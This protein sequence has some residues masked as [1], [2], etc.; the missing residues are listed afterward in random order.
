MSESPVKAAGTSA[1]PKSSPSK[2]EIDTATQALNH[3]AQGKR[4][5]VV[6]DISSAVNSLQEA[7]RLL[8]E[9][10]GETAPECGDA[11]F[12]YGRALLEMA[13]MENG[14]LGNALDGVPE[15][16]DMDNSQ[17]ENPEKMTE[18]EKIE[19]TEQVGKALEEN[20]KDLEDS[21]KNS[22]TPKQ[23][24]DAKPEESSGAKE[25]EM[26][27]DSAEVSKDSKAEDGGEKKDNVEKSEGDKKN[28]DDTDGTSSSKVEASLVDSES[29]DKESKSEKEEAVDTKDEAKEAEKVT[30]KVETKEEEG[31]TE[32]KGEGNKE[33]V[34]GE[35]KDEKGK[36]DAK[37]EEKVKTEAKEEEMETDVAE[38]KEGSTEGEEEEEEEGDGDAEG[39]GEGEGE[40]E[41]QEES[42]DEGEKDEGASQEEGE[43][44]EEDE[45]EVSNLQLS[46]EMLELAK[47]IY[48]KQQDDNPEMAKKV[49]Q[50]YLKLGEVGLESENY[51]QGIEDFKQ[52]LQIQEKILEEDNRCLAETHYQLGVAHSFS[53]DFDK[54]IESFKA[55]MKVIEMRITNL[56]KQIKEK[57]EWTE[58]Q[59]KKDAAE[60]P[61]PFYTEEGE[62][63]ELNKLLPEMKEKVTDME[64]M[65]KD[66]KDR[67]Q[68]AAKLPLDPVEAFMANAI[69]GTSKAGSSSQT[70][71]DAPSSSTSAAPTEIKASNITHLVRKKQRKP[72]DEVEG[73]E[74]KKAKG[75]NG[76]AHGTTNGTTNGT[77]GTNGHSETMET[78]EKETPSNGASTEELKEKAADEMKKKTD[79]I[80]GQTE[81]AS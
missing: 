17:V 22:K 70:G 42:Q 44:T 41:S 61:D 48:Q 57:K 56:E 73:E 14:V 40:E 76:E 7:C 52:C 77:N 35:T 72:E 27:V 18:D 6:G 13:R 66:S 62:I 71:F 25:S 55:A 60:R 2:K 47:V 80:T 9:Q 39:D 63:E 75:E 4:H 69:G 53:D 5:L 59:K 28:K 31:K 74:V 12:Y 81:A 33:K 78:E 46:W 45:E 29:V 68:K 19:V 3:F 32:E 64:E 10:Y 37:D 8:A 34:S 15:G 30:E 1:S 54:A 43:K 65:K 38:K 58:E 23:N 67:L 36:E 79:L 26:D 51:T 21:S 11:Y 49:A 16:D 50:V 24:G 20:F